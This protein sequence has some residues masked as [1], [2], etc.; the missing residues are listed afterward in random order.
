[1]VVG[2]LIQEKDINLQQKIPCLGDLWLVGKLF[3]YRRIQKSRSEIIITLMPR[4]LPYA[5]EYAVQEEIELNRA[6]NPL[7]EGP[8]HRCQRP[9]E[10]CLPDA[11]HNPQSL[12]R[13]SQV[14]GRW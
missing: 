2:G 11:I 6:E 8:L 1:M 10:P 12:L 3:Q 5:A 14:P 9:W 4:V 13:S 7:L